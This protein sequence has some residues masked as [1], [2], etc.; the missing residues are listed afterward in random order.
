L[1]PPSTKRDNEVHRTCAGVTQ[2]V[3][4]NLA[5][6]DVAGSNPVSRSIPLEQSNPSRRIA[7]RRLDDGWIP[8]VVHTFHPLLAARPVRVVPLSDRV[9][10]SSAFP[11]SRNRG[12][13]R[14]GISLGD[15]HLA[16]PRAS[17]R[18]KQPTPLAWAPVK[19]QLVSGQGRPGDGSL[20]PTAAA[21]LRPQLQ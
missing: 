21:R 9:A 20:L 16:S 5:K 19:P 8:A 3:E 7:H 10:S 4:C 1:T 15:H 18:V 14:S 12:R 6:V 17:P 13:R 2:L 11:I